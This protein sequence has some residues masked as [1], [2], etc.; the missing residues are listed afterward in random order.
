ELVGMSVPADADCTRE[1]VYTFAEE[2]AL[3]GRGEDGIVDLFRDPF[4]G[5]A[6]AALV[7]LGEEE[8]RRIARECVAVF[9][10][11]RV[12]DVAPLGPDECLDSFE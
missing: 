9:G 10:G 1:M 3:M 5:S 6:H 12:I 8:V 2:F 4:Y 11:R 7:E